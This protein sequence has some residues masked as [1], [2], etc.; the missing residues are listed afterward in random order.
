MQANF[1]A[2]LQRIYQP[3]YTSESSISEVASCQMVNSEKTVIRTIEAV[4]RDVGDT[5]KRLKSEN[6]ELRV[7]VSKLTET[8]KGIHF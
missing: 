1:L 2:A 5:E 4:L 6:L 8:V 7:I 3:E